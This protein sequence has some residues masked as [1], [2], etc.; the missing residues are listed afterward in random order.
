MDGLPKFSSMNCGEAT[1]LSTI[2]EGFFLG[3]ESK[4]PTYEH[5]YE[6]PEIFVSCKSWSCSKSSTPKRNVNRLYESVGIRNTVEGLT[7]NGTKRS[8]ASSG[9]WI[10]RLISFLTLM[11]S[12]TSILLV[13][14]ILLGKL[15]PG[16]FCE[17]GEFEVQTLVRFFAA[18]F[19][20]P[21]T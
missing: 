16:N 2:Q 18:L 9:S 13:V 15:K 12:L 7:S 10:N 14:L 1:E 11:L 3:S 4:S 19:F 5:Q 6:D 17:K 20:S 21:W 8:E